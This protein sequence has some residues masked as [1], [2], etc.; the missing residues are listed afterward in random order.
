MRI[1]RELTMVAGRWA[2]P[3]SRAS[4]SATA[5]SDSSPLMWVA[6]RRP[7]SALRTTSTR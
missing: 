6:S 5:T 7:S 2:I 3:S 1:R 4:V